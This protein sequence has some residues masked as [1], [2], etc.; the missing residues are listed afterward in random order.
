[1]NCT[2]DDDDYNCGYHTAMKS[3]VF[4]WIR[5]KVNR[6]NSRNEPKTDGNYSEIGILL[7]YYLSRQVIFEKT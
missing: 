6:D 1:M 4:S 5:K 7:C 3:D 2:F